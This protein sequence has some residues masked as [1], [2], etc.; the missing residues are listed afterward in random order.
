[1]KLP[2]LAGHYN[3]D[4]KKGL[5]QGNGVAQGIDRYEGH[6]FKGLPDGKG[7]YTWQD[8]SYY[9]G[10]WKN[11]MRNGQGKYVKGDSVLTGYWKQDEYQGKKPA[12][13][14]RVATSRNLQRYTI[15][16]SNEP[17]NGIKMKLMLGGKDN[18]EVENFSLDYSSGSE[19]RSANVYG[20]ENTS[21]PLDV[22]VRYTTWN[23]L[24]SVQYETLF[25]FTILE[26][27]TYYVTLNN[28]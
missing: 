6:F 28:M 21:I 16:K 1:V 12:S 20:L 10:N 18:T 23:Q 9:E 27:G 19:Y 5:A 15:T 14:Y 2:R 26:P 7:T 25:E 3:G 4:C 11:G 22:T 13:L 24:H 8:G 17:G